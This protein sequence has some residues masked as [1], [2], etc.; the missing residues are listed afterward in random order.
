MIYGKLPR[1]YSHQNARSNPR[2]GIACDGAF[3]R[4]VLAQSAN[5]VPLERC[6][7]LPIVKV[8]IGSTEMR[9]LVDTGA[10]T[11]LNLKSFSGG[12][13]KGIQ[14][15]SW[16]GTASRAHA[17]SRSPTSR[18]ATTTYAISTSPQLT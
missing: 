10:T 4:A 3:S 18:L 2:R 17:K 14:I 15:T 6:D 9:F 13:A 1:A 12:N 16:S 5:E 11:M 7:R 8:H